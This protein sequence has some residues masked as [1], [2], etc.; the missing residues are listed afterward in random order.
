PSATCRAGWV[1]RPGR[2]ASAFL[3]ARR[4]DKTSSSTPASGNSLADDDVHELARDDDRLADRG[5]VDVGL[6]LRGGERARHEL[7]LGTRGLDLES[8]AHFAVHLH[9][10]LERVAL[11]L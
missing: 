5:S 8:I 10:E 9:H 4:S 1:S 3:R 2:A 7:V 6:H 11:Q